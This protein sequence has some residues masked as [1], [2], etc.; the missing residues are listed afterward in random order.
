MAPKLAYKGDHMKRA[1]FS[2]LTVFLVQSQLSFADDNTCEKEFGLDVAYC[3]QSRDFSVLEP[4]DR[5]A[6][7]KAC[8]DDAKA[9]KELCESGS[10]DQC[11]NTCEATYNSSVGICEQTYTQTVLN[12]GPNLICIAIAENTRAACIASA[13]TVFNTCVANCAAF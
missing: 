7:Q 3:A 11:L 8:V 9:T 13:V 12:C 2:L 5:G 6:E 1:I 10:G 4:K